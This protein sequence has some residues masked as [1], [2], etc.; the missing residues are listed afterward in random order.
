MHGGLEREMGC[1][2]VEEEV[3]GAAEGPYGE[4]GCG[5]FNVC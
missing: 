2:R 3:G 5:T 4:H 1:A